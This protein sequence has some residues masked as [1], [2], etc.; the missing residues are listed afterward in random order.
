MT[1]SLQLTLIFFHVLTLLDFY[2]FPWQCFVVDVVV[3]VVNNF[4]S[5]SRVAHIHRNML[6][7]TGAR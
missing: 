6:P 3:I 5:S 2:L 4:L 7:C 1:S